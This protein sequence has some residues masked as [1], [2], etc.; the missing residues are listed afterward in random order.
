LGLTA[1]EM[2]ENEDLWKEENGLDRSAVSASAEL[3]S[4]GVTSGGMDGD[5]SN[6]DQAGE[7]PPEGADPA[8]SAANQPAGQ[9]PA[10]P[11]A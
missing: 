11:P 8:A 10:P 5:M 4:A 1:E 2:A 6:L 7:L 9:T 3:R